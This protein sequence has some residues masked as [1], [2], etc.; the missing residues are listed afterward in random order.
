MYQRKKQEMIKIRKT[1]YYKILLVDQIVDKLI[2]FDVN[3]RK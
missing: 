2:V 1:P 3:G